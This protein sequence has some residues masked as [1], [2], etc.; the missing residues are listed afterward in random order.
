MK[1]PGASNAEGSEKLDYRLNE[2]LLS[3]GFRNRWFREYGSLDV[4]AVADYYTVGRFALLALLARLSLLVKDERNRGR[5]ALG[6]SSVS[7]IG[8]GF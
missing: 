8:Q 7:T 4:D 5:V 1:K 6:T 2:T 3:M